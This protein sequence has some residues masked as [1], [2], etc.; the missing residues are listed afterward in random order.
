[1]QSSKRI[2]VRQVIPNRENEEDPGDEKLMTLGRLDEVRTNP[3]DTNMT[4]QQ[5]PEHGSNLMLVQEPNGTISLKMISETQ[6]K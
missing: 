4:I 1:M 3:R 2:P 6:Q 5:I